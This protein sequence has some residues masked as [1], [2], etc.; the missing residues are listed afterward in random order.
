MDNFLNYKMIPIVPK[1]Y[2]VDSFDIGFFNIDL[3][4]SASFTVFLNYQGV[5]VNSIMMSLSGDDYKNWGND[6]SYIYTF[7]A[8]K[9]GLTLNP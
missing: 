7:V 6:D 2:I 8:Q 9:L 1:T 4:N 5:R 3:K